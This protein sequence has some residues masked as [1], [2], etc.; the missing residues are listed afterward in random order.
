M[1]LAYVLLAHKNPAQ[2][3]QLFRAIH[4]PDDVFVLHVDV[5][6]D[7][8]LHALCRQ[9]CQQH[10]NVFMLPPRPVLWGGAEMVRVQIEG[11]AMALERSG[12]WSHC[13]TLTGQDFPIK[14][15][16]QIVA[17]LAQQPELSHVGWFDPFEAKVWSNAKDRVSRYY[18]ESAR[19]EALLK[20]RFVGRRIRAMLGWRNSLPHI[21]FYRRQWPSNLR[22]LGGPNHVMLTREAAKYMAHDPQARQLA[23]WLRHCAHADE[24]VF[25]TTLL[26]SPLAA[27]VDNDAL[28]EI[29]FA[30]HSPSPRVFTIDDLPRLLASPALFARKFDTSVDA[31][32][33]AALSE[34]MMNAERRGMP[35]EPLVTASS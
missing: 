34:A 2:L 17:R 31:S 4:H 14:T 8:Q 11:M 7:A 9:L 25:Q 29:D 19:L 12:Q 20:I 1:A 21:P 30:L 18:I 22:Y 16:E 6:A 32:I 10:G 15:R 24:I 27:K 26:N 35:A 13:I 33:L 23:D 3:S 5:R 28:R